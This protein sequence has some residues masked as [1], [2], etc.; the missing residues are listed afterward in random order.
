[1]CHEEREL[2]NSHVIPEFMYLD[3]YDDIHRAIKVESDPETGERFLQKGEREH[4]FCDTCEAR[5]S[6]F[7]RYCSPIVKS[8][9]LLKV[10][11]ED[12]TYLVRG[13]DY[14]LFKL[15]QLSLLW[16]ASVASVAMFAN[17]GL[18]PHDEVLRRAIL[19]EDPGP[20]DQYAC[21]MMA[22]PNTRY[23]H[24]ILWSPETDHIDGITVYRFQTG[25]L[26]WFFFLPNQIPLGA[27]MNFLNEDGVL[28]VPRA[29]WPEEVILQRLAGRI[30]EAHKRRN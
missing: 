21:L 30:A 5:L 14:K 18:G 11:E 8:L 2:R 29:P 15:F 3:M 27:E 7:E 17:I 26:F 13:V 19:S 10:E 28:R 6:R 23:L 12:G 16:R 20:P 25:R 1:L 24:R 9:Y 22:V 4:L